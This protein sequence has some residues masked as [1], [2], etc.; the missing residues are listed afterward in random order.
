MENEDKVFGSASAAAA[1]LQRQ[2]SPHYVLD[3]RLRLVTITFPGKVNA[4]VIAAY[5]ESLRSNPRFDP[6]FAEIVDLRNVEQLDLKAEEF[7]RLAD[8]VD[9][10]STSAKRAF[11]VGNAVQHHAA[12]MHKILRLQRNFAIFES[13]EEARAWISI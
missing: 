10:F 7:I 8:Q 12:R 1:C 6:D 11:V 3:A 2:K 4:P 5:A 13:L 9:P